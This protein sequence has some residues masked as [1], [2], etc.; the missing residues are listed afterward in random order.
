MVSDLKLLYINKTNASRAKYKR[1]RLSSSNMVKK[2]PRNSLLFLWLWTSNPLCL[3]PEGFKHYSKPL[4]NLYANYIYALSTK[5]LVKWEKKLEKGSGCLKSEFQG[6]ELEIVNPLNEAKKEP[7]V[8]SLGCQDEFEIRGQKTEVTQLRRL[9]PYDR[10]CKG[11]GDSEGQRG[12]K[13]RA[14]APLWFPQGWNLYFTSLL[15]LKHG[16]QWLTGIISESYLYHF[17]NTCSSE[18]QNQLKSNLSK[19]K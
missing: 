13:W 15:Y 7:L 8:S 9:M 2:W 18:F 10:A 19:K 17:E 1:Q 14:P 5:W 4:Y 12:C 3:W 11:T 6:Q 16:D